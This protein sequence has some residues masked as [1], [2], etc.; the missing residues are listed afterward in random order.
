MVE[1]YQAT[2]GKLMF[3]IVTFKE[4]TSE[5]TLDQVALDGR[6]P[7]ESDNVRQ[8]VEGSSVKA[9]WEVC[10]RRRDG[11]RVTREMMWIRD[12]GGSDIGG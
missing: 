1:S 11:V 10:A 4:D 12:E 9:D 2:Q 3:G 5:A 6:E 8:W 7:T